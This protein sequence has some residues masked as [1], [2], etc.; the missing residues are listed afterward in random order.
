MKIIVFKTLPV[1]LHHIHLHKL[2]AQQ[3][4]AKTFSIVLHGIYSKTASKRMIQEG[5]ILSPAKWKDIVWQTSAVLFVNYH[6]CQ[7]LYK[8][9]L[10]KYFL[11]L[12]S[13]K[14]F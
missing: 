6:V 3:Q 4:L 1:I 11:L 9:M 8:H 2:N 13:K 14:Y 7:P 5:H 10:D 12:T